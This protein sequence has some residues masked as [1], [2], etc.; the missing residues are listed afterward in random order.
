MERISITGISNKNRF[1][2]YENIN[3]SLILTIEVKLFL[4]VQLVCELNKKKASSLDK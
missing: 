1:I 3:A 2:M 4:T